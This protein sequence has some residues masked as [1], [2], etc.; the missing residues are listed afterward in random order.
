[1]NITA[2]KVTTLDYKSAMIWGKYEL[3]YKVGSVVTARAHT[4]GIMLFNTLQQA[5][6]FLGQSRFHKI[7]EVITL[8]QVYKA[9]VIQISQYF[10][11]YAIEW[12]YD[13]PSKSCTAAAPEG[14][15]CCHKVRVVRE[16][17]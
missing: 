10:H 11:S 1:M 12:F 3:S 5:K 17:Q 15:I 7:L 16:V 6:S 9:D 13:T 14:T 4:L 2:Y 8:A